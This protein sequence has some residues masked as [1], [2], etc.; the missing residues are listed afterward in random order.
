MKVRTAK[1]AWKKQVKEETEGCLEDERCFKSSNVAKW[2][3][4]NCRWNGV[5]QTNYVT[6]DETR[7]KLN[8]NYTLI[9]K[10]NCAIY[11][12]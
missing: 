2:S 7:K 8:S 9:D 4:K 6:G 5:N 10:K 1:G 3:A 12:S 11:Y